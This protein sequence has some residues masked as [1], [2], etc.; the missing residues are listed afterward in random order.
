MMKRTIHSVWYGF[1]ILFIIIGMSACE[2]A[3]HE[4]EWQE[5]YT[6]G[7][8]FQEFEHLV[9]PLETKVQGAENV[10][11]RSTNQRLTTNNQEGY[12][13]YWSFNA[14]SLMPD[15]YPSTHWDITYNQGQIPGEYATGWAHEDYAAGNALSLKGLEEL[16][17]Q[18]PLTNVSEVH[19][20]AFDVSSSG[21]G[22]KSFALLFSQDG[23]DF[24]V[25]E[26]ESQFTNTNTAQARNSFAF[27]LD[28]LSLDFS[29]DLY[30]RLVPAAGD[31]GN[32]GEYNETTGIM[33][34]D[35]F[36]LSGVA[37]AIADANVRR[38]HYHVFDAET[39]ELVLSGVDH[40]REGEL[41]DFGL[42]LPAG[43]YIASFVTN[44]SQAE[45]DIPETG[46]ASEYFIASTF[47]NHEAKIFGV[48]DTFSVSGD[49][50]KE[51]ELN[52]YYSEIKFAFTDTQDLSHIAKLVVKREHEP[53]FYTP[54]QQAMDNPVRDTS[55]IT[56]VPAFNED[57]R[58]VF[59]N[60]FMGN[61]PEVIPLIYTVEAYD[62]DDEMVSTF[63]VEGEI[64]NNVQLLFRGN[65]L[66]APNGQFVVRLNEDW[67]GEK[68]VEF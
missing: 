23:M 2:K 54:F 35:N 20:L 31:R 34:I 57:N 5:S 25:L 12:V 3:P 27:S 45:L 19:E 47:S 13:Y 68:L 60:Q 55:E 33:R 63:Q 64:R 67:E 21:T 58:E 66:D 41:S 62:V 61:V 51:I 22:P 10:G 49:M 9:S 48:L 59:F 17:F 30:I 7:F 28:E 18:M 46:N 52:R 53:L 16:T 15:S 11:K 14:E 42:V 36:R 4:D 65:L 26:E 43:D 50:N 32:A 8:K 6:V 40:F 37:E 56:I 44:V 1:S 29:K 39:K 38:I 24:T